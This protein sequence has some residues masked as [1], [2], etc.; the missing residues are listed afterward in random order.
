MVMNLITAVCCLFILY[1]TFSY[2]K[3]LWRLW[4][5]LNSWAANSSL[6]DLTQTYPGLKSLN[7]NYERELCEFEGIGT[8][9]KVRA[10]NVYSRSNIAHAIGINLKAISSA[11]GLI[12]GLGVLGTFIGLTISVF[13]F[14]SNSSEAIMRS[15]QLLLGGMG[16][17]FLTSVIGMGASSLYIK[18]Q[19]KLYNRFDIAIDNWCKE[20]DQKNYLSDIDLLRR[21]NAANQQAL[22]EKL[23]ALQALSTEQHTAHMESIKE[24]AGQVKEQTQ[25]ITGQVKTLNETVSVQGT[26][27]ETLSK[28]V[29]ESTENGKKLLEAM[30]TFDDE[31][32]AITPGDML[33]NLYDESEKQSRSLESF[34]TDLS[35]ELN[36]SLG[37]TMDTSIVPLIQ[38]LE[39]SHKLFNEKLDQLASNIQ[40]PA[41]DMVTTVVDELK[42]SM[43][44][45]TGEFKDTIS[46]DTINQMESLSD[47]LSKTSTMLNEIP[48]TMQLMTSAIAENFNSIKDIIMGLQSAVESQ[49]KD[50][51]SNSKATNDAVISEMKI[52]F[53]E[54]MTSV[55]STLSNLNEQ[56]NELIT[57]QDENAK[58]TIKLMSES[59]N[60]NVSNM[61][62]AFGNLQATLVS[63]QKDLIT[64]SKTANEAVV[65]EM[66][67][68]FEELM[69]SVAGTLSS[70]NE[71]HN[72][73]ISK[74][75]DTAKDTIRLMSESVSTNVA[76]M[77]EA[78]SG[79]QSSAASQ[80]QA[81][82]ASLKKANEEMAASMKTKFE[83]LSSAISAT[84]TNLNE[85]QNNLINGQG[86]ST[87][88]IERLLTSFSES[89]N[90]M[91]QTNLETQ[92]VL[93]KV[94]TIGSHLE[95]STERFNSLSALMKETSEGLMSQ[96]KENMQQYKEV[97]AANQETVDNINEALDT[98]KQLIDEYT[99]QYEVIKQGLT[100]IFEEISKGLQ[101]YSATLRTSTGDALSEY[102]SA[103]EKSTKGL[104]NI[105]EALNESAEELS[106]GVDKLKGF[107]R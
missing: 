34:T 6:F 83:S 41:T 24:M 89:V 31:G 15:I 52:R 35:N 82:M 18:Y 50:M 79:M 74:Q 62:E 3:L 60:D 71:Q 33:N 90:K 73:L 8:K 54:L 64:S 2:S 93:V 23:Q 46:H 53:E 66:K 98:T 4:K 91:K 95:E 48:Q 1:V 16:T 72:N 99:Q 19:K 94:Q 67:A 88:E 21:E 28:E 30:I 100:G 80:Q 70:L 47:S 5:F 49:Q 20:L 39:K 57:Q 102:S 87:R 105:A 45:M 104:Q 44:Q 85:Q 9:S 84:L 11:S 69:T 107:R 27:L 58:G 106:D 36:A 96:Q 55:A 25:S 63:Q 92:Q 78:F 101:D 76:N 32:N 14:N 29:T 81:V 26:S 59:V 37:R 43:K 68:R 86:R 61:K 51:L 75:D 40:S 22:V 12:S 7:D 17:A 13:M 77:K 97:Q 56:H 103:L 38:D 10:E 65:N 42:S